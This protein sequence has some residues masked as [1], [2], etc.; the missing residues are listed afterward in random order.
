LRPLIRRVLDIRMLPHRSTAWLVLVVGLT[1]AG[2]KEKPSTEPPPT[3]RVVVARPVVIPVQ[4]YN[5][6][7]GFLDTTET[8]EV[9]ARVKGLLTA[10]HFKEGAEVKK[11]E[12]LYEIDQREYIT[13]EKKA[14]SE[15]ERSKADVLNW[16]AQIELAKAE[17]ERATTANKSGVG[18]KT[19]LDKAKAQLDVNKAQKDAAIASVDSAE[20]ALQTARIQLGYTK[21]YAEIDGRI[22]QTR[23]TRGNLVGQ[24]DATLL[25]TIVRM[26]ELYAFFDAPEG[27]LVQYQRAAIDSPQPDPT[28]RKIEIEVRVA[29]ENGFAHPGKIDFREN[30]VDTATGT[31][32]IRARVPNPEEN[33]TRALYPGLYASLR[34]PVGEPKPQPVLPEDCLMTGQEGRFVL[35]VGQGDIVE[36]KLVTVGP[37]VWRA[38]PVIPGKTA[39]GWMLENLNATPPNPGQPTMQARRSVKSL[40]AVTANLTPDDRVI[41]EGVQRARPG[42]KVIPELWTLQPPQTKPK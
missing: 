10:I 28:S 42:E 13:A 1:A 23:V 14:K 18:S 30:R 32:R 3:P 35:V 37:G 5:E 26:D 38:P 15:L 2:C 6:Y 27:D 19:D 9:R 16:E 7:N 25:T 40:F 29:G 34:V 39:S 8:V 17:L 11:G 20:A 22:S 24:N 36:K 31:V 33:G 41:V 21:I 12:L 4:A